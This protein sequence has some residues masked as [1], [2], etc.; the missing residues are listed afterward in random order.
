M[1]LYTYRVKNQAGKILTGESKMKS[2]AELAA[3]LEEKGLAIVEIREKNALTDISQISFLKKKVKTKDLAIFCRQFAIVLE[4]G[5][6]MATAMDVLREQAT[7]PTMKRALGDLY[8]DIQK[9]IQLSGSMKKH[10]EFPE[11][12]VNM[13]ESGEISGQLDRVFARMAENFEKEFKLNQKIKG[14][15]TYPVIVC[16]VAAGVIFIMMTKVVPSFAGILEGFGVELPLF[17]RILISVSNFFK[18]FWWL[19]LGGIIGLAAAGKAFSASNQ[20]KH[21]F[22][23]LAIRLPV[24]KNVTRNIMTARLT[25]TLGTLMTSGVLLIQAMEIVQKILGNIIIAEKVEEVISEVKKGKG[26][27]QPLGAVKYFPPM[28]ISM[29]KIGE[30]SGNLD[31]ALEKSA[32]FY[33]QEVETSLQQL[34]SLIEPIVIIAMALVVAFVILSILYPMMSI[35]QNM[36]A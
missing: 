18:A 12:L 29:I 14:A 3:I 4:A 35:Y 30:E 13:V 36:S 6:P 2:E 32:D 27:T 1:P 34:T 25:R 21:F 31:F 16:C 10:P 9:G 23:G 7:H 8:E 19:I 26:L 24:M 20:G 15:L 17:T 28:L 5:V 22:G 11:M 33:D